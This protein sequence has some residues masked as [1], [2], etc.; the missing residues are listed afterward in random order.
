MDIITTIQQ[1]LVGRNADF[2]ASKKIKLVRHQDNRKASER[3]ILNELYKGSLYNLYQTDK[4]RFLDYQS[5]QKRSNFENVEYIVAFIGEPNSEARFIGVF[6]NNGIKEYKDEE[7]CI[8]DFQEVADDFDILKERTIIDWGKSARSW[9]QSFDTN[10]KAV[11]RIDRG[12]NDNNTPL[13]K[14]YEEVILSYDQLKHIIDTE[15]KE[16]KNRL[17]AC[18]C[19]YLILD[20]NNGQQYVGSTYNKSG[21]WGRWKE[22][23]TTGHGNDI[24]LKRLLDKDPDYASKNFQWCILE[25]L[26][27]T[28]LEDAA[29]DRE[30][31]YKTKFGTREHGYNNN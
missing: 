16:W 14:S 13:F 30:S 22:Y 20:K 23:A 10:P 11:V 21:I 1:L 17:T 4:K 9:Q 26:P 19:I 8:F 25:T 28:I 15:N 5:E 24:T 2:D 29:I 18:N 6:K 7:N 31:L 12:L 3:L 27:L